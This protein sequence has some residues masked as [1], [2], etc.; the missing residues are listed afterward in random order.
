MLDDPSPEPN[1]LDVPNPNPDVPVVLVPP[2]PVVFGV[3][4]VLPGLV[5]CGPP[6]KDP[7]GLLVLV[8]FAVLPF[9]VG[10]ERL[11]GGG[12]GFLG[13]APERPRTAGWFGFTFVE[14][15]RVGL[16]GGADRLSPPSAEEVPLI[17]I[18]STNRGK[19]YRTETWPLSLTL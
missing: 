19:D 1:T 2:K 4:V 5:D 9:V 11:K 10:V 14:G 7:P 18:Q 6:K 3:T 12:F 13:V 16:F 17:S 15:S 8:P